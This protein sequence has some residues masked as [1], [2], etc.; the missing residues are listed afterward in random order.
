MRDP[1]DDPPIINP[2]RPRDACRLFFGGTVGRW[3]KDEKT[4]E[5]ISKADQMIA[6]HFVP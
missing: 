2:A 6:A 1:A 5:E 4:N 3:R